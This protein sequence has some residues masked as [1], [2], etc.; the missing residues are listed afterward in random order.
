MHKDIATSLVSAAFSCKRVTIDYY[1]IK[2]QRLCVDAGKGWMGVRGCSLTKQIIFICKTVSIWKCF[3]GPAGNTND[4]STPIEFRRGTHRNSSQPVG[5][6]N[7]AAPRL[8]TSSCNGMRA[9]NNNSVLWAR[10]IRKQLNE[11]KASSRAS[12]LMDWE[13]S[14]SSIALD[15]WR[16]KPCQAGCGW[17][18]GWFGLVR[19]ISA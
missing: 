7:E 9:T 10:A 16:F 13:M 15:K 8:P 5:W 11:E 19:M 6:I 1:R 18:A 4:S 14:A 17:V 2:S 3:Y 12:D